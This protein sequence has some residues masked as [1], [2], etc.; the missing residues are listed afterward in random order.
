MKTFEEQLVE[1]LA[2]TGRYAENTEALYQSFKRRLAAEAARE[3]LSV[4][5]QT[6]LAILLKMQEVDAP[7]ESVE[8]IVNSVNILMRIALTGR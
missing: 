5:Q 6:R 2:D 3:Q 8:Q 7:V 4:E 1:Q